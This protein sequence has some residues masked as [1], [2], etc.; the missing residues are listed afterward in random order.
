MSIMGKDYIDELDALIEEPF[1]E[2]GTITGSGDFGVLLALT[3][4]KLGSSAVAVTRALN[5]RRGASPSVLYVIEVGTSVPDAAMVIVSLEADLQDP[6][7]RELQTLAMRKT[8]HLDREPVAAW[9]M[10]LAVGNAAR[11][12]VERAERNGAKIVVLGLNRHGTTGRV[13]GRDT[14]NGVMAIGGVP[15]LAVRPELIDLPKRIV[16]PVDFSR[17]SI[18]A[19]HL[20]RRIVDEHGTMHLVFVEPA[21]P[22]FRTESEEAS[23]LIHARGVE[24]A[25]SQLVAELWP[26]VGVKIN[27]AVRRGGPVA[28]ITRFA[29]EC[30]ADLI[31][32]GSQ[33]HPFLDR[34]LVGSVASAIAADARWSVLV[35]PPDRAIHR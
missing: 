27:T 34:L 6:R 2:R 15:V 20:A 11:V 4:D 12:I 35:T 32:I 3:D 28:E 1:A 31:A 14:V 10:T 19:A 5:E 7:T 23:E 9:A 21:R 16:V 17:A 22:Q 25:F 29:E 24:A 13:M 26:S 18:R 33:R 8:L 30:D